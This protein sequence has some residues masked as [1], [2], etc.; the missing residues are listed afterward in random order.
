MTIPWNKGL[1]VNS[2]ERIRNYGKKISKS[3][4]GKPKQK[5]SEEQKQ[6]IS[7]SMKKAQKEGRAWN[8]GKS[9]WNNKP[10]YAENF[11]YKNNQK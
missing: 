9:R 4:K 5:M 11:F 7:I 6:K 2:D 10:S 1:S 3:L 8:I